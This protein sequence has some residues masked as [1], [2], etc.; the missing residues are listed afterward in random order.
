MAKWGENMDLGEGDA[1]RSA[2]TG[3]RS[4][5]NALCY[6]TNACMNGSIIIFS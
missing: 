4:I 6:L 3:A 5:V 2:W 1:C